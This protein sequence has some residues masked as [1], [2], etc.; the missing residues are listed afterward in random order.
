MLEFGAG[1]L[2]FVLLFISKYS[3]VKLLLQKKQVAFSLTTIVL[4]ELF[5]ILLLYISIDKYKLNGIR[6][7][8]GFMVTA[9]ICGIIYGI[10]LRE[11]GKDGK[12]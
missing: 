6:I 8:I 1:F 5:L 2:S 9:L 7:V 10:K 3:L 11:N 4:S 12:L